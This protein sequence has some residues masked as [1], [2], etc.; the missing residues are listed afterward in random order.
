MTS[1]GE[2]LGRLGTRFA[3]LG[4]FAVVACGS[5]PPLF[6]ADAGAERRL[7]LSVDLRLRIESDWGSQTASGVER[8]DRTRLR[9]RARAALS[10]RASE[11]LEL[12]LR[13]RSGA[14]ASQ[15]S[16]HLTLADF[17]GGDTGDA[18]FNF[19]RWYVKARGEGWSGWAG[20][21][22]FPFWTQNELFWDADVTPVG[23]A[24]SFDRS[25]GQGGEWTANLAYLYLPVG[26][27]ALAGELLGGQVVYSS[28]GDRR[29]TVAAGYFEI[30]S[31]S[32]DSDAASLLR[33]NGLRDYEIWT[34]S[35]RFALVPGGR[36]LVLGAD[37]FA[38]VE[39]YSESDPH[40]VTAAN[41][42]Q[43]DGWA[44][45]AQWRRLET[46]GDWQVAYTYA[47]IEALS[48]NASYAQDDWVRW[49]STTE[50][51]ASDLRGHELRYARRFGRGLSLVARLF[52]VE[53]ITSEEDGN[54]FRIDLNYR[55]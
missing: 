6:A 20:R 41:H 8:D 52:L 50:T 27:R 30:R 36:P 42:D 19:D 10:F 43:T 22:G 53:A 25:S 17:D 29:L 2:T 54:R 46:R 16:P 55:L 48:V 38:N 51:R 15:Q 5:L 39:D 47:E 12:G 7:G 40:P 11:R 14:D 26:M 44:L 9:G 35:A 33:G 4:V 23:V 13:L 32:E 31:D 1:R 45:S 18:D 28:P 34:A 3:R 37:F 21:N 24:A 49:G